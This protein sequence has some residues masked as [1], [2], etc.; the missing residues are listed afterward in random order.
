[1][2]RATPSH[3]M[4]VQCPSNNLGLSA[5]YLGSSNSAFTCP[6]AKEAIPVI[7]RPSQWLRESVQLKGLP[8]HGED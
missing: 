2:I 5:V 4:E 7:N 3:G 8:V 1:M 6:Y